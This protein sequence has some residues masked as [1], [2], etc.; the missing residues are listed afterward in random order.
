M[1]N[2]DLTGRVALV[3]G[4]GSGIGEACAWELARLGAA[5]AVTDLSGDA[6]EL[7]A[8]SIEDAGGVA[9]SRQLDVADP[10][11]VDACVEDVVREAGGLH[12]AVNNAGIALP[13]NPLTEVTD[14][15][16]RT[17]LAVNLS[18]VFH[19]LRAELRAMRASG[20]GSI[21]NVSS[22]LGRVARPGSAA[23]TATKHGV[24]GMTLGAAVDHA[25][26]GIRVNAVGPGFVRT[27]LL[28]RRHDEAA[29]AAVTD[30]WPL[31]RLGEPVEIA[32]AVAWLA[33]DASSFVTGTCLP[34]DG[35]YL[36]C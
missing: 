20:G 22:V 28:L 24:I 34:V 33:S 32:Q 29:L 9:F 23:Y 6:A 10:D 16:W 2:S 31:E 36:A 21:V 7:V 18:G 25:A 1:S 35:G 19:C 14:D 13:M 15:Q 26:D 5:V 27:P 11:S 8:T 3:T 30:R 17:V 4:A 12:V